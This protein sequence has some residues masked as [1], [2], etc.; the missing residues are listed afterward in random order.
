MELIRYPKGCG[1]KLAWGA[2]KNDFQSSGKIY[3]AKSQSYP[4]KKK[5]FQM[6]KC[7]YF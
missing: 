6:T 1:Y 2:L 3:F 7:K 5:T 4:D